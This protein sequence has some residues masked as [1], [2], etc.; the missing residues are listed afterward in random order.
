MR[1]GEPGVTLRFALTFCLATGRPGL[2]ISCFLDALS[3][4]DRK[5]APL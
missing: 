1:M 2:V 5:R 4:Q 3:L